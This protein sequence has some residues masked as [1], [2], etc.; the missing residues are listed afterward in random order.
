MRLAVIDCGT[1]TFNLIIIEL[2]GRKNYTK[3]FKTRIPVKLGEG[4]INQGF[5]APAS[6]ERGIEAIRSLNEYIQQHHVDTV[7]SFATSAIR[8]AANGKE[9]IEKIKSDFGIEVS[10]IDGHREAEL[11]YYGI[12]EA[13]NMTD[14]VSLIVDIGGGSTEFILA[15]KDKI[16]WKES[17]RIGAARLLEKFTP[18]DPIRPEE[19][20]N[21]RDYLTEELSVLFEA[22]KQHLPGELIGSSGAF[23]S[24]V[25]MIHGEMGGEPL[26]DFKTEYEVPLKDY[27]QITEL[28]KRSTLQERRQIKGLVPM[29][30]DMIVISCVM[31][32]FILQV[33]DLKKLRVSIYSLKEGV[34]ADFM[35][36]LTKE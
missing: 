14:E 17:F 27:A 28:V 36:K 8:D 15:D 7:L 18:S 9:F 5:I 13:V 10:V 33:F 26:T 11:I 21:I 30:F 1:N 3:L 35:N 12:R 34:V 6:F 24:L 4:A 32:D 2:E 25:E 29:R 23:D 22:V 19:I 31:V 20:K 16:L